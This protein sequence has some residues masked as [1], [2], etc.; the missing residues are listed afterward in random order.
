MWHPPSTQ[1]RQASGQPGPTRGHCLCKHGAQW[2]ALLPCRRACRTRCASAGLQRGQ[3]PQQAAPRGGRSSEA[4]AAASAAVGGAAAAGA[5]ATAARIDLQPTCMYRGSQVEPAAE[6]GRRRRAK[7]RPNPG[8]RQH[9]CGSPLCRLE[10]LWTKANEHSACSEVAQVAADNA[11]PAKST[12]AVAGVQTHLLC[13][14]A[15]SFVP[16]SFLCCCEARSERLWP[17]AQPRAEPPPV[18]RLR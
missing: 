3:R 10:G 9:R 16:C 8:W 5:S 17:A 4:P 14:C 7:P 2:A 18:C 15:R 12:G 1:V 6:Q 13:L 11:R